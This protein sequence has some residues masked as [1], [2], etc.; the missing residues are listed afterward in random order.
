MAGRVRCRAAVRE[1]GFSFIEL[2]VALALLS[3]AVFAHFAL[4]GVL[5]LDSNVGQQHLRAHWF[6]ADWIAQGPGQRSTRSC[7]KVWLCPGHAS[8]TV[9]IRPRC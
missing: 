5:F 8:P 6:G 1:D 3:T 2:L 9:L 4:H 7:I